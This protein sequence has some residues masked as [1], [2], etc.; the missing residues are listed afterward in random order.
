MTR[1]VEELRRESERNRAELAATVDRLREQLTD[2][3]EELRYKVS[4]Q[5]IKSEVS[6]FVSRKTYSWLDGL[7]QRAMENPMQAIAAG[8]AVAVPALRLARG[9]P[10]PLLMMGA[11]LVLTS[12][13]M[14]ARAADAAAPAA[15]KVKEMA[16]EAASRVRSFGEGAID[17]ASRTGRDVADKLSEAQARAAGMADDL[18]DRAVRSTDRVKASLDAASETAKAKIEQ[19][20]SN[21]R[22]KANAAPETA[23]QM[24]GDNAALIAGLGVAFGAIIAASLPAT[25]AEAAVFGKASVGV[26]RTTG[27]AVQSGL[28][29]AKDAVLSAADGA[30]KNLSQADLGKTASHMT[31]EMSDKLKEAADDI[32]S[33]AFNPANP[34]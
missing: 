14:R 29:E 12:K 34:R 7:K 9:F 18:A 22:D 19:V 31:R 3:A 1:S 28:E 30:A 15:E 5:G 10:L 33:A 6:E 25:Q 21:V 32:V 2:T 4:P 13:S 24:I 26:K 8:T 11:G 17:A 20:R 16:G 27:Q 23:Q